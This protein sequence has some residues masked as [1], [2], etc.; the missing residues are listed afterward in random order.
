MPFVC[1]RNR[2]RGAGFADSYRSDIDKSPAGENGSGK[3]GQV[4][5]RADGRQQFRDL[6]SLRGGTRPGAHRY[7]RQDNQP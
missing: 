4:M 6:R 1:V 7:N 3:R 5:L 2:N